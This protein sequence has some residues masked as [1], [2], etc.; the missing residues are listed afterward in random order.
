MDNHSNNWVAEY[1]TIPYVDGGRSDNGLDCWGLVR[2]VLHKH[3]NHPLF[4]SFGN[5]HPDNKQ[6]MH[7]GFKCVASEFKTSEIETASVAAGL[8]NNCLI[9]V[10]VVL[11]I[12]G[13]LKVLHTSRRH[14]VALNTIREFNR[15]FP[16]VVFYKYD[17]NN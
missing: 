13:R 7:E 5:V 9:H 14:G 1:L 8:R 11:F 2:N 15:L 10:G 3:F 6:A 16:Q 12:D 4:E 17:R